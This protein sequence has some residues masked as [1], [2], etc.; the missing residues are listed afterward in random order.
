MTAVLWWAVSAAAAY[1]GLY[2]TAGTD[3]RA[4]LRLYGAC[5]LSA[6]TIAILLWS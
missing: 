1:A 6:L 5:A 3:R 4:T 2:L